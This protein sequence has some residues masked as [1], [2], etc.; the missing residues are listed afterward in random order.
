MAYSYFDQLD[1]DSSAKSRYQAKL[2]LINSDECSYK[3]PAGVWKNNPCNW[4]DLQF[5]DVYSY[6][7]DSPGN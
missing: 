4:P 7:I 6:L 3:L 1:N 2:L 5:D